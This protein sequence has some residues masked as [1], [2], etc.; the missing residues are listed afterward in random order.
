MIPDS[1]LLRQFWADK[2]DAA[3]RQL[4]ERHLSMVYF[5]AL[6]RVGGDQHLAQD[7]SQEV[8]TIL[9]RKAQSLSSRQN[10]AGWLY[11]AAQYQAT[12][13]VREAQRRRARELAAHPELLRPEQIQVEWERQRPVI[14][15]VLQ[16]LSEPDR[17]V[18]L[19]RFFYG[20]GYAD[21]GSRVGKTADAV[22][23]R[24]DR[25]LEKMR[26]GLRKRGVDSTAAAIS[27]ALASQAEA[28]VPSTLLE[29]IT[30][31]GLAR[32]AQASSVGTAGWSLGSFAALFATAGAV[33]AIGLALREHQRCTAAKETAK[34]AALAYSASFKDLVHWRDQVAA[35]A[36]AAHKRRGVAEERP[37]KL[38]GNAL[39]SGSA[40]GAASHPADLAAL[41]NDPVVR[42]DFTAYFKALQLVRMG[43]FLR[44]H[45]FTEAEI[46]R[47][48]SDELQEGKM[49]I[50]SLSIQL[51]P[52]SVSVSQVAGDLQQIVAAKA[53]PQEF[54]AGLGMSQLNDVVQG[55]AGGL[56]GTSTPLTGEQGRLLSQL[57][58]ENSPAVVPG[59]SAPKPA[60][61]DWT[62]V[63]AR[64]G[65]FLS[66]AQIEILQANAALFSAGGSVNSL[67]PGSMGASPTLSD[68]IFAASSP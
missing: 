41:A 3:F 27:M 31:V 45:S 7:V 19:Q 53:D 68:R 54:Y 37:T 67:I 4:V 10:L 55:V 30:S 57:I 44:A 42:G 8:F 32:T 63:V 6:R 21:I 34:N 25:A 61:T 36:A 18:I 20:F 29:K 5:A 49:G 14:D 11:L 38:A 26:K 40:S 1:V 48:L 12:H 58:A 13:A 51:R 39:P 33:V 62:T 64:A 56:A 47:I 15:E 52:D 50:G 9:A 24:A 65:S 17:E 60:D 66:P 16:T 2:S 28:A 23:L 35:N 43:P 22:R 46:D 59:H